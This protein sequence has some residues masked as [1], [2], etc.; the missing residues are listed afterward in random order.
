MRVLLKGV[1]CAAL[2]MTAATASQLAA[3]APAHAQG[4]APTEAEVREGWVR[5]AARLA[6]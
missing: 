3:V 5:I 1:F 2:M 6:G 4:G